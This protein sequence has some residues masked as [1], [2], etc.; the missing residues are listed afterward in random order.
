[1]SQAQS[2]ASVDG[3]TTPRTTSTQKRG[4]A[5]KSTSKATKTYTVT[6]ELLAEEVYLATSEDI[7]GLALETDTLEEMVEEM[8][9]NIPWLLEG[10]H[11]T[12]VAKKDLSIG[13][14]GK[15]T[16]RKVTYT[17]SHPV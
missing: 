14:K 4:A 15:T 2:V 10:N 11:G 9:E 5:T 17:V 12:R 8:R 16:G 13:C 1:M 3:G 7:D 6:V